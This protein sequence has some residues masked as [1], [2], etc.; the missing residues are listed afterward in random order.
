MLQRKNYLAFKHIFYNIF[1]FF[2][3]YILKSCFLLNKK[4][5]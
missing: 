3:W 5:N 4:I 2:I 1:S